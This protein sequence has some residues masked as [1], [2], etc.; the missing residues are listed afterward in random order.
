MHVVLHRAIPLPL[1]PDDEV[2]SV[3]AHVF[4]RFPCGVARLVGTLSDVAGQTGVHRWRVVT[5]H[6]EYVPVEHAAVGTLAAVLGDGAA[7][8]AN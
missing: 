8:R 4:V 2:W 7:V 3:D 1:T 6:P 5:C